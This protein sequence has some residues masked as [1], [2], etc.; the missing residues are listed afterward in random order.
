MQDKTLTIDVYDQATSKLLSITAD[1][2]VL[3]TG[4]EPRVDLKD[5]LK[6]P[7]DE[8]D[9]FKEN[10]QNLATNETSIKGIFLTGTVQ[11]PMNITETMAHASAAAMKAIL[12]EKNLK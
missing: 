2:I 8:N 7:I 12:Q 10:G 11:E 5:K 3:E 6:L 9:F 4:L 1:L